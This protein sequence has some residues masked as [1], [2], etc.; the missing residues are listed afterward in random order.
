MTPDP[1]PQPPEDRDVSVRVLRNT[2]GI[3]LLLAALV[4]LV[5]P[6]LQWLLILAIA[7]ALIDLPIKSRAHRGLMRYG[8]YRKLAG[9]WHRWQDW[10]R[11]RPRG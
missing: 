4:G 9:T 7:I 1:D 8:W 2:A 3:L 10:W 5:L 11:K 6:I